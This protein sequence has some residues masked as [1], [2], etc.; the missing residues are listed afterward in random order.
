MKGHRSC[1]VFA[2]S[3]ILYI[4]SRSPSVCLCVTRQFHVLIRRRNRPGQSDSENGIRPGQSDFCTG[5][6]RGRFCNPSL[7]PFV[8]PSVRPSV[9]SSVR[10]SVCPSVCSFVR[11]SVCPFVHLSDRQARATRQKDLGNFRFSGLGISTLG[12]GFSHSRFPRSKP[13]NF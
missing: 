9:R 13:K 8:R 3:Y 12:P 2:Q 1:Q 10:P 6:L 5:N 11:P 7:C 4:N